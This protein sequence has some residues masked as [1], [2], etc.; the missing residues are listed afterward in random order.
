MNYK[1]LAKAIGI[2]TALIV[3]FQIVFHGGFTLLMRIPEPARYVAMCGFGIAVA[4]FLFY[5]ALKFKEHL[6]A[7]DD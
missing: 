4:T 7:G 2:A 5:K 6:D 3:G 1:I